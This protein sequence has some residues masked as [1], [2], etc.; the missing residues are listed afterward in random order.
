MLGNGLKPSLWPTF[1]RRFGI[2]KIVEFY[3]A[4]ETNAILVN[5]LGKEGAC[6]FFHRSVPRW[7]LKLVYPIDLVK[8]NEVTGEVIR[9][10][11]GFCDSVP[12]S[13]GSGLFVGKI[14][15]NPMQRFDGYVNRSESEKKVIKDVFKKGDSF[16][17][18]GD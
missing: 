12:Q 8:A 2:Q 18:S 5:L 1:Q 9:N 7:V 6:G 15:D 3:G 14:K 17:S 13:G 4:T 10:E 11:K 16:F